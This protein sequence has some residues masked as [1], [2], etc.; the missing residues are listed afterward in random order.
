[1]I[2]IS[3]CDYLVPVIPLIGESSCILQYNRYLISRSCL[4]LAWGVLWCLCGGPGQYSHQNPR[5]CFDHFAFRF[6]LP[7]P[8]SGGRPS[9]YWSPL[10]SFVFGSAESTWEFTPYPPSPSPLSIYRLDSWLPCVRWQIMEVTPHHC[11]S[12]YLA[13][14]TTFLLLPLVFYILNSET[15]LASRDAEKG[16][17]TCVAFLRGVRAGEE[18]WPHSLRKTH[19]HL[20][21]TFWMFTRHCSP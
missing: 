8:S 5:I 3:K 16:L 17:K 14:M 12:R 10:C 7:S 1:M 20:A 18:W 13:V 9:G 21:L 19:P 6:L 15:Q 4:K 2:Q 11:P